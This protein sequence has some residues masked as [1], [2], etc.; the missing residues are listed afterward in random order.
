LRADVPIASADERCETCRFFKPHAGAGSHAGICLRWPP[1]SVGNWWSWPEV[2][3]GDWCGE[4]M[5]RERALG[6]F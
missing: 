2:D 6:S 1:S 5:I 4:W 3:A